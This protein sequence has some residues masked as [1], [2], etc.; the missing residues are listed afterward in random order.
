MPHF[1]PIVFGIAFAALVV[2]LTALARR[3]PIP[4]PILQ[5]AA[6]LLIAWPSSVVIPQLDPDV[7]FFVFL[8]PILWSAA[9]FTSLREFKKNIRPINYLA[10]GLVLVTTVT[11]ACF[12]RIL[13][14]GVPWA[15]A[16]ALGAIVSPPD[17][18]A[19]AAIVSRLPVP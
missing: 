4:S 9:F 5:V 6:G 2:A 15:V 8:P 14:P 16:I 7:V 10:I 3:L 11:V 13:L 18:V 1:P 17:A 19:A 12:A